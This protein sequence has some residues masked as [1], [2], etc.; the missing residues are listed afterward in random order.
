MNIKLNEYGL[1][2]SLIEAVNILRGAIGTKLSKKDK[3]IKIA[4]AI[5]IIDTARI[6]VIVSEPEEEQEDNDAQ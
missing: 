5:G 1:D 6:M 4:E 3:D 2:N